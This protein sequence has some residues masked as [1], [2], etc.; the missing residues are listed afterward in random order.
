MIFLAIGLP[1]G[2]A[3]WCDDVIGALVR[4]AMGPFEI[5]SG[6]TL[7]E[8]ACVAIRSRVPRLVIAARQPREDLRAALVATGKRFVLV[9]DDP[10]AAF[11][12]LIVRHGLE[13]KTAIRAT[14]SGC[15]SVLG[16]AGLPGA[17]VL[18]ADR[19]GHDRSA[20]AAAIAKWLD[21]TISPAAIA[22]VV[23]DLPDAAAVSARTEMEAWWNGVSSGDRAMVDG[24]LAGYSE[25]SGA[26]KTGQFIWARDLF[27]IGD[28]PN[29]DAD[30]AIDITGPVRN[31]V[32]GPYIALPAGRWQ[33]TVV[34]AV[35]QQGK[36]LP[37]GV[38]VLAG[39][40]CD[41]LAR[42]TAESHSEG[43]VEISADFA[44]SEHTAQPISVRVANLRPAGT[45]RLALAHVI[46]TPRLKPP[47][48]IPAELRRALGLA[49]TGA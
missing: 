30:R 33:V 19:D 38:E 2:F 11:Y 25:Q 43:I 17:L 37:Y 22:A 49:E 48:D 40:A 8:I 47:A 46:V 26:D 31:L 6:N 15:A 39:P 44:I 42:G 1:S 36:D 10:Y 24:A 41:C 5:A 14:A 20:V 35:S 12:N 23:R 9:L 3:E 7:D 45:G 28:A 32:F 21:L 16:F 4:T 18:K 13:W 29:T 27:F 34:L